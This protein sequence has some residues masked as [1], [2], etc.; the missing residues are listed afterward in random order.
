M[1]AV[2]VNTRKQVVIGSV[3][4]LYLNVTLATSGDTLNTGFENVLFSAAQPATNAPTVIAQS[5]GGTTPVTLTFTTGGAWTGNL[6]V[7]GT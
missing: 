1:A 3:R 5:G 7:I 4:A 2:T 6:E